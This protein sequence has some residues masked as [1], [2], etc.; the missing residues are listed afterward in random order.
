MFE[1]LIDGGGQVT[2]GFGCTPF[3]PEC[4][5]DGFVCPSRCFHAGIDI[6]RVGI[7]GAAVHALGYGAVVRIG[8][9]CYGPAAVIV[10]SGAFDILYGHLDDAVV[11]V[12][13]PVTPGQVVGHAGW[14][15]CVFPAGPAG[16]HLHYAAIR[17]GGDLCFDTVNPSPFLSGWPGAAP[18]PPPPVPPPPPAA[19]PGGGVAALALLA[20]LGIAGYALS[21]NPRL[22]EVRRG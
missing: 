14:Q 16:S 4:P 21:R 19:P 7:E 3:C 15:G 10:R 22:L 13:Q 11:S 18:P 17:A 8:A 5:V 9:P 12:T 1:N 20:G 6:S 2:Q